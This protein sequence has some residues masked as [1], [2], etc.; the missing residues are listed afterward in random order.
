MSKDL[1]IVLIVVGG[2]I[3]L[4]GVGVGAVVLWVKSSLPQMQKMGQEVTAEGQAFGAKTDGNGCVEEALQRADACDG[5]LCEVGAGIFL[6]SCLRAAEI[7][8][9]FCDGVPSP[10]SIMASVSYRTTTCGER[11]ST[12]VE[13]CGRII[14]AIQEYCHDEVTSTDGT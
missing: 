4:G 2:L 11:G 13:R 7:S 12:N 10:E 3:L 8:P 9:E 6:R 14:A 1:K 5:F